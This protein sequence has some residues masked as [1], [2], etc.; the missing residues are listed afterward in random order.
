MPLALVPSARTQFLLCFQSLPPTTLEG[1][2]AL[3]GSWGSEDTQKMLSHGLK[4][5]FKDQKP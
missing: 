5:V 4:G 2:E 1:L 3:E